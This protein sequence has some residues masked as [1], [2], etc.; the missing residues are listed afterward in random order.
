MDAAAVYHAAQGMDVS[1]AEALI[2]ASEQE[3]ERAARVAIAAIA[4]ELRTKGLEPVASAV[5]GNDAKPLPAL[6]AILRS[7]A[8]VHAA[9]GRL[10]RSIV[11]RACEACGIR[12]ILVPAKE[13][14]RHAMGALATSEAEMKA[15]LTALGKASG[16]PWA[17]DE[18][19]SALAAFIALASSRSG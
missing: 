16:R 14:S 2:R 15:R 1:K 4:A 13:L 7:H 6:D 10:F 11:A 5:V 18:K 17:Q 12:A 19:E 3:F 8:L 9:E